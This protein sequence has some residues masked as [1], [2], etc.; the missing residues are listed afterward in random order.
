MGTLLKTRVRGGILTITERELLLGEGWLG[1]QNVKHIPIH[2]I[3]GV[4]LQPSPSERL[5]NR[6]TLLRLV[7]GD[8]NVTEVDGI[9]P[10]AA[11]RVRDLL[12]TLSKK[13]AQ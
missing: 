7:W 13:E 1:T 9:G 5:L 3:I 11:Q 12:R 8:G 6:S 2:L 10:I 4:D